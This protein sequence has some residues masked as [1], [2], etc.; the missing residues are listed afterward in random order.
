MAI[1][2]AVRPSGLTVPI[3]AAAVVGMVLFA[4]LAVFPNMHNPTL[5]HSFR[6]LLGGIGGI[7]LGVFLISLINRNVP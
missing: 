3:V 5:A 1:R 7:A 4:M 6:I 2:R